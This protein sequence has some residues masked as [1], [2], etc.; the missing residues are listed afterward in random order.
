MVL[1]VQSHPEDH[2][3]CGDCDFIRL[4]FGDSIYSLISPVLQ[5]QYQNININIDQKTT[6]SIK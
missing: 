1:W 5:F 6:S 3:Y 4:I 2:L